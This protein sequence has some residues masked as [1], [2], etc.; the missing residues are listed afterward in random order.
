MEAS[1]PRC[2]VN[3]IGEM[4]LLDSAHDVL[5]ESFCK[6]LNETEHSMDQLFTYRLM[7]GRKDEAFDDDEGCVV[8]CKCREIQSTQSF[9]AKVTK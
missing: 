8:Y 9:V 5:M 6:L 4:P 2:S 1:N 7:M 3:Q